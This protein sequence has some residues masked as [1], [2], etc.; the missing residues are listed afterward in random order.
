[1]YTQKTS[2]DPVSMCW[3]ERKQS[4]TVVNELHGENR[5]Y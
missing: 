1:M 2:L 4:P 3:Y 5:Y